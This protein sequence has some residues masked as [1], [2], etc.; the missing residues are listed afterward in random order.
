[1]N[2]DENATGTPDRALLQPAFSVHPGHARGL[3]KNA[4]RAYLGD[5]DIL[6]GGIPQSGQNTV[7]SAATL[8]FTD[9]SAQRSV[10]DLLGRAGLPAGQRD[11]PVFAERLRPAFQQAHPRA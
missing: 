11:T 6:S 3:S 2:T 10:Q 4:G 5:V 8:A 9:G 1:M 7:H